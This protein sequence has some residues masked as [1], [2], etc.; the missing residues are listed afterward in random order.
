M[1]KFLWAPEPLLNNNY[2]DDASNNNYSHRYFLEMAGMMWYVL[3]ALPCLTIMTTRWSSTY[4][5][6]LFI[7]KLT[8]QNV[9]STKAGISVCVD[10]WSLDWAF[11][12]Q[13]VIQF[14]RVGIPTHTSIWIS[15]SGG[16]TGNPGAE[17]L[18]ISSHRRPFHPQPGESLLPFSNDGSCLLSTLTPEY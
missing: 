14:W 16:L 6:S 15:I 2:A 8:N 5:C 13:V 12:N 11:Q 3:Y 4:Y 1:G 18:L 17:V 9:G 10:H 7:E